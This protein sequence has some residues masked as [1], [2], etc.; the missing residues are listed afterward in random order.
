MR[1]FDVEVNLTEL[2]PKNLEL[3]RLRGGN[4]DPA[5]ASQ[6]FLS[7]SCKLGRDVLD[8]LHAQLRLLAALAPDAVAMLDLSAFHAKTGDWMRDAA[9][10]RVPPAPTSF[11]SIHSPS[12][13]D[14][15]LSL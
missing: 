10:A 14:Q 3:A 8:S 4:F 7:V 13:D 1:R 15:K 12:V 2:L 5:L 9:S 6:F 11:V